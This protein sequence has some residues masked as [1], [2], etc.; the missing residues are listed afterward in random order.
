MKKQ[1]LFKTVA[2]DS[3]RQVVG[4]I[5]SDGSDDAAFERDELGNL[6]AS[7]NAAA[8]VAL[9]LSDI[10]MATN[11]TGEIGDLSFS[12]NRECDAQSRLARFAITET[13]YEQNFDYAEDGRLV[14]VS[15]DDAVVT[16]AYTP[17]RQDAGYMICLP[18]GNCFARTVERDAYRR[19]L[20]TSISN[21]SGFMIG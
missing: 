16:Y 3:R 21:A 20:I 11:E 5:S 7:S 18:N 13:E 15:N 10:G 14:I 6:V 19:E 17:D 9:A 1:I 12:L 2:Y 8:S 4:R